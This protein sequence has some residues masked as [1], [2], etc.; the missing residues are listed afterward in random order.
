[1]CLIFTICAMATFGSSFYSAWQNIR[2]DGSNFTLLLFLFFFLYTYPFHFE[3][4][5]PYVHLCPQKWLTWL[6]RGCCLELEKYHDLIIP[7]PGKHSRYL[8]YPISVPS[9]QEIIWNLCD[10]LGYNLIFFFRPHEPHAHS[11]GRIQI[12]NCPLT[13]YN[14]VMERFE[15]LIT[16]SK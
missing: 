12:T 4:S 16:S 14:N 6:K 1:M 11:V 5:V 7:D 9:V 15:I 8:A 2:V 3:D 10:S 13:N